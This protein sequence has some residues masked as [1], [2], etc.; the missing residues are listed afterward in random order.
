MFIETQRIGRLEDQGEFE[1]YRNT[2]N[3]TLGRIGR[4]EDQGEFDVYRNTE[5]DAWRT[6]ENLT[7]IETQR[8]GR[9]EDQGEFDVYR[10]TGNWTFGGP[11]RI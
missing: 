4:L 8:I 11:R 1:V 3:W 7:F 2:E 10:N 5:L 6:K 9:L